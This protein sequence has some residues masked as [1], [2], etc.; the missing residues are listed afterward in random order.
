MLVTSDLSANTCPV[1]EG[2]SRAETRIIVRELHQNSESG[3]A[4]FG[5][6]PV[7]DF[8]L[9]LWYRNRNEST[10]RTVGGICPGT[11]LVISNPELVRRFRTELEINGLRLADYRLRQFSTGGYAI[12]IR[13]R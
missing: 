8:E 6:S 10:R 3:P 4:E 12:G 1:T 9:Y 2:E 13:M 11:P 7:K 5:I